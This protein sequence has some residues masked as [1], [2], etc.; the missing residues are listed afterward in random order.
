LS[1]PCEAKKRFNDLLVESLLECME[2]GD[3]AL[4]FLELKTAIKRDEII[5]KPEQFAKELEDLYGDSA[6]IIL[7]KTTRTFYAKI[8]MS[9]VKKE[10]Y[11]FSDYIRD[12]YQKQLRR[13]QP[14]T[15][16]AKSE[17]AS[18]ES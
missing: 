2:F 6:K 12:V 14:A 9:Y 4:R 8:G 7:E 17:A 3:V 18:G 15:T 1:A 10:G 13:K 11:T 16:R 5:E